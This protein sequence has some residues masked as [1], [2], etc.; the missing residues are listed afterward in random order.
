MKPRLADLNGDGVADLWGEVQGELR[1]FRGEAPEAW[2]ALGQFHPADE[3][4]ER[5][6]VLTRAGVDFDGDGIR[7]ALI[8]SV[9][10]PGDSARQTSGSHTALARSGRDGRVIWKT[11]LDRRENWFEPSR[12]DRYMLM[13]FPLPAGDF[14]GDGTPDVIVQ[15]NVRQ[16]RASWRPG[17]PRRCRSRFFPGRLRSALW[18]AGPLP[19]GFDAAGHS[20]VTWVEAR[21]VEPNGTPDLLVLHGSPFAKPGSTPLTRASRGTPSLS[22]IS[23][24]DGRIVWDIP[25]AEGEEENYQYVPPPHFVDLNGDGGLDILLVVPPIESAGQT[26]FQLL[27]ISLRD[28]SRLWSHALRFHRNLVGQVCVGD[29]DGDK[30]PEVVVMEELLVGNNIELE[31]IALGGQSGKVRW[32]RK[33]GPMFQGLPARQIALS[34]LEGKG[35]REVCLNFRERGG[36]RRILVLDR[37]GNERAHRDVPG[38]DNSSFNSTDIN[39]D[40]RDELLVWYGDRLHALGHDLNDLWSWPTKSAEVEEIFPAA[41]GR[42]GAVIIHPAFAL[43]G[44]TGQPRWTGQSPLFFWPPSIAPKVL[45]PGGITPSAFLIETGEH[46]TVG[47]AALPTTPQGMPAPPLGNVVRQGELP[48]D[49]RWSRPLPWLAWLKGPFGPWGFLAAAGLA[50]INVILPFSILRRVA[51]QRRFSI[52]A[53]MMLPLAAAIPI[54]VYLMLEPVLPVGSSPLFGSEKRLFIAGTVAGLPIVVAMVLAARA[55]ARG[56]WR[57]LATLGVLTLLTSLV[58][59]ALWVWFD[60]KSMSSIERYGRPGWYLIAL[61]GVYATSM[62]VLIHGMMRGIFAFIRRPNSARANVP[63]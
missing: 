48:D 38:D 53:L 4:I 9:R 19:L 45:S 40:G 6:D 23:G 61:P 57:P 8:P 42:P 10:T 54:M 20:S 7:D 28:G 43:D 33:I 31:A 62:L 11:V 29:L 34:D 18:S 12:G 52:R 32:S 63:Q 30:R 41:P 1:A 46:W 21:T 16:L 44:A 58:I 5:Q 25:L 49:P 17:E 59:A 13:A 15:K 3:R 56:R 24:R 14:D 37:A 22:R 55:L 36:M 39:G 26:E 47:R 60:M 35:A 27:A 2:R 50:F 51:G